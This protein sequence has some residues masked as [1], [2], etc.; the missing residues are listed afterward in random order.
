[1]CYL[2]TV[3]KHSEIILFSKLSK[4][5]RIRGQE[6]SAEMKDKMNTYEQQLAEY[7]LVLPDAVT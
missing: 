3:R 6:S 1:V 5:Q 7:A 2:T 4:R